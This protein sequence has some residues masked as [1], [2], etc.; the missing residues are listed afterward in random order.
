M[1]SGI[2]L[3]S[4]CLERAPRT[5]GIDAAASEGERDVV[6]IVADHITLFFRKRA[7]IIILAFFT[8]AALC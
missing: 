6:I 1:G 4:V 7:K 3:A 5:V 2:P 8:Y